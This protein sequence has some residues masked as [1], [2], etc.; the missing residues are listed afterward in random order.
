VGDVP[1]I[2]TRLLLFLSSYFPL[3][4]IFFVILV[5]EHRKIASG[6][7]AIGLGGLLW[8]L[9]YLRKAQTLGG[10]QIKIVEFHRRDAEA[11]AYIVTY[12]IPFFVIPFHGW[13]E[14]VALAIFF[15]VLG[16]LYVNS[17]LIHI[18][19]MLNLFGYH[20]YEI[21]AEDGGVHSL[22]ARRTIRH[23]ESIIVVKLGDEILL[24][25]RNAE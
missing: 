25:K 10:V 17:N 8:M 12:I 21:I 19:P 5:H 2:L 11:M 1:S 13:K 20:L 9:L 6:I 15:V 23:K 3:S 7:L 24:E 22:L 14:G 4:L 16:I 18:N